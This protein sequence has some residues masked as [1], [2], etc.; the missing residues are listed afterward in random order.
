MTMK[1]TALFCISS[2]GLGHATRTLPI[3]RSYLS[4][5]E[6]HIASHGNALDYLKKDLAS[7]GVSF[8]EMKD[9]PPLE[10]G[11][12]WKSYFYMVVD[13]LSTVFIIRREHSFI[14]SLAE[15]IRPEFIVSDGR[16]GSYVDSVPSFIISHQISFVM[17]R[18]FG[19]FQGFADHFNYKAFKNFDSLLIPDYDDPEQNLSGKLSRHKMLEKLNHRH[20]G[21]LS[22]I[23]VTKVKQDIDFLFTISG[24]LMDDKESFISKLLEQARI[25][26]G[27]KVFVLGNAKDDSRKVLDGGDIEIYG[28]A[29]GELRQNLFNRAKCIVSRS[30]YTTIMDLVESGKISFL[31][32]TPGQTEQ[33]YLAKHLSN[34]FLTGSSQSFDLGVVD[35]HAAGKNVAPAPWKTDQ[36]V[37]IVRETIS[38]C[39]RPNFFSFVIPVHNEEKYLDQTLIALS[40]LKYPRDSFEVIVVENGSKDKTYD[41]AKSYE[42]RGFKV[43]VSEKGASKAK[44]F[45]M[46]K[47]SDGSDWIIFLDAD[48]IV[49][50]GFLSDLDAYLKSRRKENLTVGTT[51]L[52]P[53]GKKRLYA[54]AWFAF[55]NFGHMVTKTSFAIQIMKSSYRFQVGFD[56]NRTFTEDLRLLKALRKFGTFFF[57]RTKTVITSVRRF[58]EIGWF[59]LF[60]KWNWQALVLSHMKK[61]SKPYDVVR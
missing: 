5:H 3:I 38:K 19:I 57:F 11:K 55:Y 29:F 6:I 31:I 13:S 60:F 21:I 44:N 17:P 39:L 12:G 45:G 22:N 14:Q 59:K 48:T 40:E 41:I 33:E 1:P 32:P 15:K 50:P 58:D 54:D 61:E 53:D 7:L 23:K 9:Y 18:G 10:R 43:Y 4:S 27:K 37:K 42:N 46:G 56:E 49:R 25:L 35:F 30:G 16:Y 51:E 36:S 34:R 47:V 20:V 2:L 28:S 24:Y 52:L 8:H 26:P